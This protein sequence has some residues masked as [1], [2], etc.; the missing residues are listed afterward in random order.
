MV[1]PEVLLSYRL[2][3]NPPSGYLKECRSRALDLCYVRLAFITIRG[4]RVSLCE[5]FVTSKRW[6]SH[7]G[8]KTEAKVQGPSKKNTLKPNSTKSVRKQTP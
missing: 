1:K 8:L 5:K 6:T 4:Y 3:W 7:G 2:F